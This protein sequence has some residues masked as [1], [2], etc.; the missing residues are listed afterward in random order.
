MSDTKVTVDQDAIP[1]L[2]LPL[3]QVTQMEGYTRPRDFGTARAASLLIRTNGSPGGLADAVRNA[4]WQ[5]DSDQPVEVQTMVQLVERSLEP[6]EFSA[7]TVSA[8]AGVALIL[9]L[10]GIYGTLAYAVTSRTRE[11][12]I[13][14]AMGAQREDIFKSIV[15][16]AVALVIVGVAIGQL[17]SWWLTRWLEGN[18]YGVEQLDPAVLAGVAVAV[19]L[20]SLLAAYL[21]ARR[22]MAVDPN[23]A[24][25]QE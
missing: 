7:F 23:I 17:A 21:P 5:V 14:L 15:G 16:R 6:Q 8:F 4:V 9:A 3:R 10:V 11:I 2:Y 19:A 24:L 22:A 1:M 13:C 12:G 25:R 20:A 18:I